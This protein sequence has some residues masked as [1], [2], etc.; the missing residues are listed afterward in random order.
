MRLHHGLAGS[1]GV[2]FLVL[3]L[4]AGA[5]APTWR[6]DTAKSLIGFSG[7]QTGAPFSGKFTRYTAA[8]AFDPDHPDA[9]HL[10]VTVD[11]ASAVT[12]D[13]QRDSA[14][15][16]ADWFDTAHAPQATFTS[17]AIEKKADGSYQAKGTLSLRGFAHPVVLP[18]T[19]Q[20][21]GATAHAKGHA[22]L[23]RTDFGVGQGAWSSS[24]WVALEVGV[25]VDIVATRG[26]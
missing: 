15:P 3:P 20:I 26:N 2:L 10:N 23:I 16:G 11:L 14:L 18:F 7:A 19:L 12:G 8:I 5:E 24:Q 21:Q 25:D 6:V 4:T 13:P 1:F 9:S 17:T 22:E